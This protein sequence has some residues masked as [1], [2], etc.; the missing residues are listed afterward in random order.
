MSQTQGG[1]I[2]SEQQ[3]AFLSYFYLLLLALTNDL[4]I[5]LSIILTINCV[6]ERKIGTF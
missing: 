5:N 6:L 3:F 2:Q 4:S 1:L